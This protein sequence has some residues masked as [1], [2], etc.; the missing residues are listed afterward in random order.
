[1]FAI[2]VS[3]I[4]GA[5]VGFVVCGLLSTNDLTEGGEKDA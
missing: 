2:A 5:S 4:L 1:M 3:F